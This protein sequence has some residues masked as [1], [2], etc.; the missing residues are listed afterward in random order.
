[1]EPKEIN[2]AAAGKSGGR[3]STNDAKSRGRFSR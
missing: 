2:A 3:V 1:M